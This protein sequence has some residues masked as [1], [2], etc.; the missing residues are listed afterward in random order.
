MITVDEP[1]DQLWCITRTTTNGYNFDAIRHFFTSSILFIHLEARGSPINA[2]PLL[3]SF[4]LK[5]VI[6]GDRF[7][8]MS[9]LLWCC[10]LCFNI[11]RK[12]RKTIL[13]SIHPSTI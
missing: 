4:L 8:P 12:E 13:N 9:T 6:F 7:Y 11:D 5:S 3:L 2:D 1:L 10:V